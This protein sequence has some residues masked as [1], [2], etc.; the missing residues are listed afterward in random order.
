MKT[1]ISALDSAAAFTCT[2]GITASEVEGR[3]VAALD[4][5]KAVMLTIPSASDG[6]TATLTL[7]P[8]ADLSPY[9]RL[10]LSLKSFRKGGPPGAAFRAIGEFAYKIDLG[11]GKEFWV[12]VWGQLTDATLDISALTSAERIRVTVLHQDAD[13]LVLSNAVAYETELPRDVFEGLAEPIEAALL[14]LAGE[15][16]SGGTV[17]A[18]AGETDIEVEG[19][20][21]VERNA[22][23]QIGSGAT[24]ELRRVTNEVDGLF[25]LDTPLANTHSSAPVLVRLPVLFGQF[26]KEIPLPGVTLWGMDP[27]PLHRED[28]RVERVAHWDGTQFTMM[29]EGQACRWRVTIDCVSRHYEPVAIMSAAVRRALGRGVVYVNGRPHDVFHDQNPNEQEPVEGAEDI[30]RVQ[31][32]LYLETK[33]ELCPPGKLPK[34]LSRSLSVALS[35]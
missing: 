17:S 4:L 14:E 27:E 23:L 7:A 6:E 2:G 29:R 3:L 12:P 21:F 30:Y 31:Y 22:Y 13:Y 16:L 35:G 25:T 24:K 1:R 33:E 19:A 34:T 26:E 32:M 5:S 20:S 18:A 28:P 10:V 11:A 15:G 9:S 8:A